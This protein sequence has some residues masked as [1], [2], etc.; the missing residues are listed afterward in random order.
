MELQQLELFLSVAKE[1]SFDRVAEQRFT[2]QRTISRQIRKLE[3][4][5]GVTLFNRKSNS[6]SLTA[7]GKV[8]V[9]KAQN[10][11]IEMNR[12]IDQLQKVQAQKQYNLNF[13]FYSM[14]DGTLMRDEI[15]AFKKAHANLPVS[16]NINQESIEQILADLTMRKID[17]G[18]VIEYGS[19][20]IL[21]R[22]LFNFLSVC[23]DHMALWM[24]KENP[25]AKKDKITEEELQKQILLFYNNDSTQYF[26]DCFHTT[27]K[28]SPNSF[29]IKQYYSIE[30]EMIRCS[31]NQGI[32]YLPNF[33]AQRFLVIGPNIVEKEFA[34]KRINQDFNLS[35]VYRKD[36][37]SPVVRSFVNF[38]KKGGLIY[39]HDD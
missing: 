12:T 19:Y 29:H 5:I 39:D 14:F 9:D 25:L 33:L 6:I 4:E 7:A 11:I 22:N 31:L 36:N 38:V 23:K 24:S 30:E 10:Y 26:I 18:Y 37:K 8:F 21:N 16:F 15:L 27:L 2:S 35:L 3:Q 13:G 20:P 32:A 17:I 1:G 34:S 28:N